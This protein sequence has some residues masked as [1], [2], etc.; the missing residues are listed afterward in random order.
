MKPLL[1]LHLETDNEK[2]RI[3][4]LRRPEGEEPEPLVVDKKL[5]EFIN[6]AAHRAATKYNRNSFGLFSK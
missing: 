5:H 1:Q 2:A 4:D 3:E 6:S